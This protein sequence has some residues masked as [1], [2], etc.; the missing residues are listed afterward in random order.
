MREHALAVIGVLLIAVITVLGDYFLKM[1]D[2]EKP[3]KGFYIALGC[4]IY[5]ATGLAWFQ[6]MRH[7]KL[8]TLGSLFCVFMVLLMAIL[9]AVVFNERLSRIEMF[10]ILLGVLSVFLL[11]RFSQRDT[12]AHQ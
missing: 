10:G 2:T 6:V 5:G 4:L 1:A 9:G 3:L 12:T 11:A 7:L 8:A